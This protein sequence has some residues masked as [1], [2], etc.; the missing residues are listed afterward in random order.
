MRLRI[1]RTGGV[2]I[3]IWVEIPVGEGEA[4]FFFKKKERTSNSQNKLVKKAS[5]TE[6]LA[7]GHQIR[8]LPKLRLGLQFEVWIASIMKIAVKTR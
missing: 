4:G 6:N 8:K 5:A 1:G 3:K 2:F 7:S